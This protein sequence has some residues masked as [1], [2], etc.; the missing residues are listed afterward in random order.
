MLCA[1][2]TEDGLDVV[3]DSSSLASDHC[4]DLQAVCLQ[5]H[6]FDAADESVF[7]IGHDAIRDGKSWS[8]AKRLMSAAV[9]RSASDAS[10]SS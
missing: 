8:V 10:V 4:D 1:V 5:F 7:D 6:R 9:A 2:F 3:C